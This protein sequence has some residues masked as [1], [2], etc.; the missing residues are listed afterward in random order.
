MEENSKAEEI[1]EKCLTRL[2]NRFARYRLSN[3]RVICVPCKL[4]FN[5]SN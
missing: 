1:C 2:D 3:Q 4:K 5:E